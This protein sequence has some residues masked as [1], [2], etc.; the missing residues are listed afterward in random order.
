[1]FQAILRVLTRPIPFFHALGQDASLARW[2]AGVALLVSALSALS[3]YTFNLPQ[4]DAFGADSA[5]AAFAI[6]FAVFSAALLVLVRWLVFGL[7]V[8]VTAGMDARPWAVIGY[9]LAPYG[10]IAIVT[11]VV[12]L[13]SPATVTPIQ[14]PLD[15]PAALQAASA[16]LTQEL[17][18]SPAGRVNAFLS[19]IGLGWFL[20][21]VYLGVR[22]TTGNPGSA[23]K[24]VIALALVHLALLFVPLLLGAP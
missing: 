13:S 19:L 22:E 3:A 24:S 23:A 5:F 6:G 20:A 7:L 1:V 4:R 15:D 10:L 8:R 11:T 16:Q 21:L 2:A 12:A 18:D 9:S 17:A 14:V